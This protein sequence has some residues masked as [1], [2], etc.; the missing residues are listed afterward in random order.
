MKVNALKVCKDK[1]FDVLK[2]TIVKERGVTTVTTQ[3]PI[4]RSLL[5]AELRSLMSACLISV[6][7]FNSTFEIIGHIHSFIFKTEI[8][9]EVL[10]YLSVQTLS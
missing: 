1:L 9:A 3:C 7:E 5:R 8:S 6:E 4:H 2:A 10:T